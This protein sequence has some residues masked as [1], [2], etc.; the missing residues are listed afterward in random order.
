M[1]EGASLEHILGE[2]LVK[3]PEPYRPLVIKGMGM[4]VGAEMC[5]DP[6]LLPDYPL[7]SR[8]GD[9]FESALRESFYEGVGMG[10]AETLRRFQRTLLLPDD[11]PSPFFRKAR[12]REY[13][14]C[15]FLLQRLLSPYAGAI[16]RGFRS[17]LEQ[18]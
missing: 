16:E 11:D 15:H 17:T 6:L 1:H 13:E 4:L 2:S 7:G 9:L 18:K 10:F 5:F 12:E 8:R 14:R 3:I